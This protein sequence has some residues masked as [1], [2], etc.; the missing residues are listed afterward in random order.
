MAKLGRSRVRECEDERFNT[1]FYT[2]DLAKYK[3]ST[4]KAQTCMCTIFHP[5]IRLLC[6]RDSNPNQ[7]PQSHT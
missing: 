5:V 7:Y 4:F 6:A 1:R 3:P 2:G